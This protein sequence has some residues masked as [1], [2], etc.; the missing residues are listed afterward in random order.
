MTPFIVGRKC[1]LEG[2]KPCPWAGTASLVVLQLTSKPYDAAWA[3]Y[4][5]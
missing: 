4:D 5:L 3:V 1:L 2:L